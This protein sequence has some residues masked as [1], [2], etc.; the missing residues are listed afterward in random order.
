MAM[1]L[2][3]VAFL[4]STGCVLYEEYGAHS[5]PDFCH[6]PIAPGIWVGTTVYFNVTH[7]MWVCYAAGIAT[8]TL[9]GGLLGMT[10]DWLG[11][12]FRD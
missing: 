12:K 7:I 11:D 8:M 2:A 5:L 3:G 1:I 10:F 6:Y 9:V 4:Y